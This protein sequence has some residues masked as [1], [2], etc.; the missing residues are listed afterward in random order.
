M[1]WLVSAATHITE[2]VSDYRTHVKYLLAKETRRIG[3]ETF[4]S[5]TLFMATPYKICWY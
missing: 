2:V 1:F 4:L 5:A 3:R